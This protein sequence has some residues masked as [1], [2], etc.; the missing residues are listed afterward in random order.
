MAQ[1][2]E[3]AL[4]PA[5][6]KCRPRKVDAPHMEGS[7]HMPYGGL[8]RGDRFCG[9]RTMRLVDDLEL[10]LRVLCGIID[11][12]D[13]Q[14]LHELATRIAA[15]AREEA[16]A[17]LI[18]IDDDGLLDQIELAAVT[19][20]IEDIASYCRDAIGSGRSDPSEGDDA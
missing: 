4:R 13:A 8:D 16:E 18:G 14:D 12:N 6:A 11:S 15:Q 19:E 9:D 7:G 20:R 10:R 2:S 5:R 1:V 3:V 17:S